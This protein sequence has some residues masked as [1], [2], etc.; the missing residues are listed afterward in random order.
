M[1]HARIACPN[2]VP[3][4]SGLLVLPGYRSGHLRP[5]VQWNSTVRLVWFG[6][7]FFLFWSLVFVSWS[8]V[9]WSSFFSM[10]VHPFFFHLSLTLFLLISSE[11]GDGWMDGRTDGCVD[12]FM[13]GWMD[14]W[15]IELMDGCVDGFMD[16][17]MDGRMCGWIYGWMDDWID[18]SL[19]GWMIGLMDR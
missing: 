14:G 5:T 18:G 16:G 19:C 2:D 12:G 8:F 7:F 9:F 10:S 1:L 13:D 4:S 3:I 11:M 15:M 17:W 6:S